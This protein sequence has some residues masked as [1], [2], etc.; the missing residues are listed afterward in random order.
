ML[1][2]ETNTAPPKQFAHESIAASEMAAKPVVLGTE[3]LPWL[4]EP[5]ELTAAAVTMKDETCPPFLVASALGTS[6]RLVDA[7]QG[8]TE[9]QRENTDNMFWSRI[10][11]FVKDGY[12]PRIETMPKP[13]TEEPIH[14]MRNNGGQRVYFTFR[15]TDEGMPVVVRLAVCD[16]NKQKQ[17]MKMLSGATDKENRRL[18]SEN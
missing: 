11:N 14:V 4:N 7:A 10:G 5:V 12:H 18:M 16:K 17:V 2:Q 15:K 3:D 9:G 6:D 8:M 13:S 1:T